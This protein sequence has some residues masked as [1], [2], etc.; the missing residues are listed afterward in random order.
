M[1]RVTNRC[2]PESYRDEVG[3]TR[4]RILAHPTTRVRPAPTCG[5]GCR[6]RCRTF[7]FL[8]LGPRLVKYRTMEKTEWGIGPHSVARVNDGLIF[9]RASH[10]NAAEIQVYVDRTAPT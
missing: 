1:L 4:R 3:P 7:F 6:N 2:R 9:W 10:V 5:T 8:Q